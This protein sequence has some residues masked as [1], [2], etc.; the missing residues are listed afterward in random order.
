MR[1][2]ELVI[3]NGEFQETYNIGNGK[4]AS[5]GEII[6]L[7]EK[8]LGENINYITKINSKKGYI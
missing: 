5:I 4:G 8:K 1:A 7:V 3:K 2:L 6:Q